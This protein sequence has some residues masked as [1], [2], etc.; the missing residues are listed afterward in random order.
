LAQ[1]YAQ[2]CAASNTLFEQAALQAAHVY[3]RALWTK[4]MNCLYAT[5]YSLHEI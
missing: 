1:H 4:I 5:T 3:C 2:C